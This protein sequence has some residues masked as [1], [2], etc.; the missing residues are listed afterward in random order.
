MMTYTDYNAVLQTQVDSGELT[1]KEAELIY[2]IL[3]VGGG[4]K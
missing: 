2:N 4:G 3:F 1:V